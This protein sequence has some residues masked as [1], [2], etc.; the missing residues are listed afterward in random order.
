MP[1]VEREIARLRDS[2]QLF[3]L[4]EH[5][6]RLVLFMGYSAFSLTRLNHIGPRDIQT[7][8]L[9]EV[10]TE[11]NGAVSSKTA[12][13]QPGNAV[14]FG[15]RHGLEIFD[16]EGEIDEAQM[17]L[18]GALSISQRLKNDSHLTREHAE[19]LVIGPSE[20]VIKDFGSKNGTLVK[21]R[22]NRRAVRRGN[23]AL[24]HSRDWELPSHP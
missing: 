21:D 5:S 9:K 11:R 24:V 18:I 3:N 19:V 2:E 15:R 1:S 8:S 16:R 10:P 7:I 13:L 20:I 14:R 12:H 23:L 17:R 22:V 6:L 4:E